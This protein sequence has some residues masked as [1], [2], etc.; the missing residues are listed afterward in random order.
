MVIIC[1]KLWSSSGQIEEIS[2][3]LTIDKFSSHYGQI[4]RNSHN[5]LTIFR[6][7]TLALCAVEVIFGD[8]ESNLRLFTY[9]MNFT[10]FEYKNALTKYYGQVSMANSTDTTLP[11]CRHHR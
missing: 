8:V 1:G 2:D 10:E 5:F 11:N 6:S 9:N 7:Q 3:N 4:S